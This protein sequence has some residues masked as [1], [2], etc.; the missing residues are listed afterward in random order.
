MPS[1]YEKEIGARVAAQMKKLGYT[2]PQLA[3][4]M[5]MTS[6]SSIRKIVS[7]ENVFQWTQLAKLAAALNTSPDYLLGL[8]S[9]G[10]DANLAQVAVQ[11]LLEQ[12][13]YDRETAQL[14]ARIAVET[15]REHRALLED[16]EIEVR[17]RTKLAIAEAKLSKSSG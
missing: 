4:L 13:G 15:A 17:L 11:G 7:G 9:G 16:P 5:G 14:G 8:G 2:P 6:P 1:E 3:Q 12:L 10:L